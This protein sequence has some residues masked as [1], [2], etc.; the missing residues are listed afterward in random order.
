MK[1]CNLT[2]LI[3]QIFISYESFILTG[4]FL[5]PH[6]S[7]TN[8][9]S[10]R[11]LSMD[12]GVHLACATSTGRS[13]I[14][15]KIPLLFSKKNKSTDGKTVVSKKIQVKMLK[16]VAGTGRI[17]DI[18]QV[19]PA[20][21][22]NMLRPSQSAIAVTD[23]EIEQERKRIQ[24]MEI[25]R[26][27]AAMNIQNQLKD[28]TITIRRKAGPDGHLFGSIGPKLI[29]EDAMKNQL[30]NQAEILDP[31]R[32]KVI[33][34]IDANGNELKTDIKYVG[35]YEAKIS[36]TKD[37]DVKLKVTVQPES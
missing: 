3:V 19:T 13:K 25:E 27:S 9:E 29:M 26:N 8:T 2:I 36:L 22:Q 24:S 37:I 32:L 33:S 7:V 4:A 18:V 11:G 17:G 34:I 23:E 21:Y 10:G 20:F 31:K 6:L 30:F 1:F 12:S 15:D 16:Y 35:D 28:Q 5:P 14:Y